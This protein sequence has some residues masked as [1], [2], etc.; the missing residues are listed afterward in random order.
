MNGSFY[1]TQMAKEALQNCTISTL[2]K[3]LLLTHTSTV[4]G[5]TAQRLPEAVV[6]P[7]SLLPLLLAALLKTMDTCRHLPH[8]QE[9]VLITVLLLQELLLIITTTTTLVLLLVLLHTPHLLQLPSS[10]HLNQLT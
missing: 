8:K 3:Y 2:S 7:L 4:L 9:G 10:K 5:T 1:S 6:L